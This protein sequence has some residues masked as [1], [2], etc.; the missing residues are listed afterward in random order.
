[1]S[2]SK[3]SPARTGIAERTAKD[4]KRQYRGTAYDKRAQRH[5]RGPWTYNL[6]EARAWRVDALA[7]LQAGT[8]SAHR[9]P[10]VR[11]AAAEWLAGIESGAIRNRSG[12]PFKP[13]AVSG[14]RRDMA[15]RIMPAFGASRLAELTLPDVQRWADTLAA[16]EGL[17]P[18]TVRNVLNPLRAL[19]AWAL[20]RGLARVN[21]CANLRLPTGEKARDRIAAPSEAASLI[22]ALGPRDQAALGL[23]VYAGLR[24]GELLALDSS[25]VDLDARTLRITRSWDPEARRFV[26]PK[27]QA[28]ARTVPIIDRLATLLADHAVLT[29]HQPG[30]L[31]PGADPT[32][33]VQPIRRCA[34]A[35]APGRLRPPAAWLPRGPTHVRVADDR[36]GRQ[37]QGAVHLHGPRQHHD[38]AG[39]LR[40]PVPRRRARGSRAARR[41]PGGLRRLGPYPPPYPRRPKEVGLQ[42]GPE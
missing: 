5:L 4:G 32:L 41:L 11:E 7:R 25:A 22:A 9:G 3:R 34:C 27:S 29:D 36:G 40:P 13:S 28:G 15:N 37:R 20:R 26:E 33:P 30:L 38:H 21:P 39:P 35:C 18:S 12:R 2:A 17:A 24:L 8:L 1:M 6:A 10:T 16:D 14:Y 19:Y 23:A 42:G 31:F